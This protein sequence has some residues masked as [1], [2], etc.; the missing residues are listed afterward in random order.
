MRRMPALRPL[1]LCVVSLAIAL[2][3]FVSP[4]LSADW[5]RQ[6]GSA[7]DG[8]SREAGLFGSD[9]FGLDVAWK[10]GIGSGY[11]G[12][13]VAQGMAVTMFSDETTDFMAGIDPKKGAE[14]WRYEIGPTYKGH[15][16]SHTGPLSTPLIDAGRVFGFGPRGRFF[17]L[18][19][20]TG[21]LIWS[22]KLD[23]TVGAKKPHYGFSSSPI[24]AD[25]VL[26][27]E[28][29]GPE[30]S[31]IGLDPA[32]GDL[33]WKTGTDAVTHQSPLPFEAE[34]KK[35]IIVTGNTTMSGLEATTGEV[36]WSYEHQGSGP[37]GIWSMTPVPA[38]DGRLFL[39]Y[40][41]EGSTMVKLESS[42]DLWTVTPLWDNHWIK[43]SYNIP[44]YH[45]GHIYAFSTRILTCVNAE[46]G[47]M[48]WRSREPGDG[49][50]ALADG[51]L[52]IATKQGGLHIAEATP[53]GYHEVASVEL[54]DDLTWAEPIVANGSLFVRGL[55]ELARIDIDRGKTTL[56]DAGDEALGKSLPKLI[57][58]I[59][60]A[61]ATKKMKLVDEFMKS[62]K[63]FPVVES[64]GVVHFVYR[65]P[66]NDLAVGGDMIGARN[67]RRMTRVEGTDLHYYSTT[68]DE[69]ARVNYLFMRDFEAITDPLN[70]R[71]TMTA[72]VD[73]EME[74][75]FSGETMEMSWLSMPQWEGP[76]FLGEP[77]GKT[78]RI[79]THT[80]TSAGLEMD[81]EVHV[82]LPPGYDES[83][84]S[85]PVAYVHGGNGARER[86]DVPRA[87]DNLIGKSVAPMIAVFI[88]TTP[89]PYGS[90][91][92]YA[93]MV[94]GE[95]IP[96]IDET[97]RTIKDASGRAS[98]GTSM[99]GFP[100][101]LCALMQ[102]GTFGNI[103]LQSAAIM[104]F[105]RAVL[106]PM[107]KTPEEQPLRIYMDWGK[108]DLRNPDEHWN[109]ST[110]NSAF[111]ALLQEKGYEVAGGEVHDGTGWSSWR[112]RTDEVF[113]T[114]FPIE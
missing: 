59:D 7:G 28:A 79:A 90:P 53:E 41:D 65:G 101:L 109:M 72:V 107:V 85:Y 60:S 78:G 70:P 22:S 4:A 23:E 48:A 110:A 93:Q 81:H 96:F 38:G 58:R 39:T 88:G 98:V 62:Q 57:A 52:V 66:G 44:V 102:P 113:S 31:V 18:K 40:K 80:L 6:R 106:D 32:S 34:G 26:I 2:T 114:L 97:Y 61:P 64:N 42:D 16:G 47:E 17:A 1:V 19:L 49:F 50:L 63:N 71:T 83:A 3:L 13:V 15:D 92:P 67:E 24:M 75:S 73:A 10:H 45:D 82:Y 33:I 27:L 103:S 11:S 14:K 9:N 108:Y 37:R 12:V 69:D 77:A 99:L 20:A 54:F 104:D 111:F 86:G 100:T 29:G 51:H 87:L 76:D 89:P 94:A 105:S 46:T 25:G 30:A 84:A 112:N 56:A 21:D 91:A 36:L 74:M 8:I 68:L 5:P 95:L 55:A 35:Q 43:N